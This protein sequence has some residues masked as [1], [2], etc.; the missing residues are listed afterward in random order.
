MTQHDYDLA[1]QLFPDIRADTNNALAAILTKNSGAS[2]PGTTS[3]FMD[4]VDE[5]NDVLYRRN[6]D[7]TAWLLRDTAADTLVDIKT[8]GATLVT[9]DYRKLI[10]CNSTTDFTLTLPS[11]ATVGN[12]WRTTIKNINT[13]TVTIQRAGADTIDGAASITLA[14]GAGIDIWCGAAATF[15]S[16]GFS[17]SSANYADLGTDNE[18]LG[19]IF[20]TS[21]DSGADV[22]PFFELDRL[23]PTPAAL[24]YLGGF[25]FVGNNSSLEPVSYGFAL[26]R[27]LDPTDGSEDGAYEIYSLVAGVETLQGQWGNGLALGAVSGGGK[28]P[29]TINA[30]E[31]YK[32]GTA[33]PITKQFVGTPVTPALG[34]THNFTHGLVST[35]KFAF[36]ILKCAT[37]DIGFDVGD[38]IIL[39]GSDTAGSNRGY[40]MIRTATQIQVT[41]GS[42]AIFLVREDTGDTDGITLSRWTVNVEAYA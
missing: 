5:T 36:I 3:K 40:T 16:F 26:G 31:I 32:N 23:S 25:Y 9:S 24:D 1:N 33:L 20:I 11:A 8:A 2:A 21:T 39:Y 7:N 38:E 14:P 4:W 22:G 37:A 27:I 28:G 18:F 30:T 42:S 35:P 41:F 6:S 29:G 15:Y 19:N 34:S 17:S 12:G 13:N 10:V